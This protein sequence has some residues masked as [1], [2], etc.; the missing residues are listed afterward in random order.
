MLAVWRMGPV[1]C[2]GLDT[3]PLV[4]TGN[5]QRPRTHGRCGQ[6][7]GLSTERWAGVGRCSGVGRPVMV[8]LGE[9]GSRLLAPS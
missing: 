4:I 9:A 5:S 7:G 6:A 8:V 2:W 1:V 3:G